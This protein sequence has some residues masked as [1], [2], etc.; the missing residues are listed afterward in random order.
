MKTI[1]S[2]RKQVDTL[3]MALR[4]LANVLIFLSFVF[5]VFSIVGLQ[6]FSGSTHYACRV[7]PLQLS[8][9]IWPKRDNFG[10]CT[11]P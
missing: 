1:P 11:P 2:L 4:G 10:A 3:L 8:D 5:M 7:G 6:W 9:T